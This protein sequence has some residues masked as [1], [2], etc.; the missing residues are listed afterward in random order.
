MYIQYTYIDVSYNEYIYIYKIHD[1]PMSSE[2]P[3]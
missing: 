1:K 3:T 2:D